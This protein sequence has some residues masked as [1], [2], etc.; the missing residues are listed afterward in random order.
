MIY[1]LP[2]VG[3]GN[4][5]SI[6]IATNSSGSPARKS[7][8][9]NFCIC[10]LPLHAHREQLLAVFKRHLQCQLKKLLSDQIIH[11]LLARMAWH[12]LVMWVT[13]RLSFECG[14]LY[15]LDGTIDKGLSDYEFV[16]VKN[17]VGFC[18][19]Y[20]G[21]GLWTGRM[22]CLLLKEFSKSRCDRWPLLKNVFIFNYIGNCLTVW[23][24]E[25]Y[26]LPCFG[27]TSFTAIVIFLRSVSCLRRLSP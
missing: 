21:G 20:Q 19:P 5:P 4:S 6:C 24:Q 7:C 9:I 27:V 12:L 23:L 22:Q 8:V 2:S 15:Y 11:L 3:Q 16:P 17:I 14:R 25:S 18:P 13:K 1:W 26:L 10:R